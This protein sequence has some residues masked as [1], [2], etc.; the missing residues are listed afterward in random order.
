MLSVPVRTEQRRVAD[1]SSDAAAAC[2]QPAVH[3]LDA[4]CGQTNYSRRQLQALYRLFKQVSRQSL[5]VSREI[6]NDVHY[7]YLSSSHVHSL[8]NFY[9]QIRKLNSQLLAGPKA[10]RGGG[11]MASVV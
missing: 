11:C 5:I 8:T 6:I 9:S 2:N 10:G 1:V 4:L 7:Y 3:G